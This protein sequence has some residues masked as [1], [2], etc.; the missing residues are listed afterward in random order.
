ME[1][2]GPIRR[3]LLEADQPGE[4]LDLG[5]TETR[6]SRMVEVRT[7]AVGSGR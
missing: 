3:F 5:A 1:F 6:S 4:M 2:F 7:G